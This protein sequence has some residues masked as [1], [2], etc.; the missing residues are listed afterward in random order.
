MPGPSEAQRFFNKV[1][2]PDLDGCWCW[3]GARVRGRYGHFSSSPDGRRRLVYS[4]RWSWEYYFGPIP[5]GIDVLHK[6]DNPPCV[7]PRHLFVGTHAENMA[8]MARKGRANPPKG[9]K[10]IRAELNDEKVRF[11]R[12][13]NLSVRELARLYG[14]GP[15]CIHHARTG[16]TWKHLLCRS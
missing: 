9:E 13:S 16:R 1:S 4:H 6:C 5:E 3:T 7:N 15:T 10:N 11:I 2:I 14:V 8:D 12:S